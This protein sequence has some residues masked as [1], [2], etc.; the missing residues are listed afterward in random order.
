MVEKKNIEKRMLSDYL[1]ILY[2]WKKF[3]IINLIIV[4]VIS[5]IIAFLLPKE[6]KASSTIMIPPSQDMGLGGLSSLLGGKSSLASLGVKAF[7]MSGTSEDVILGIINSRSA[8]TDAINKFN[9]MKYY[10]TNN[11]DKA[12]K[13]FKGD[14]SFGPNEFGMIDFSVINKD[15][16][17]SADITNY[18][19]NLVDSLNIKFNIERAKDNRIFIE[20]RYTQNVSDL[21]K[22]D[23]SLYKFQKKYGI[24]A[25]PE[26][27]EVTVK[28]DAEIEAELYKKE[29][30]AYIIKQQYGENAPQYRGVLD[31]VNLLKKKVQELKDSPNLGSSSNVFFPFKEMPDIAIQYLKT[32]REVQ[33]QQEIMEIVMPMYEQAKVQEEN[34]IPTI[35]V[36]D[37]AI[38]PELKYGPKRAVIILGALFFVSFLI[39]PFV[40]WAESAVNREQ[41]QN[42]LQIK[43]ANFFKKVI[44]FYK[45]NL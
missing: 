37:K 33:I 25:V 6:Y 32:Y 43:E 19:V 17:M 40:F 23:N 34:S 30:A 21:K 16:K 5:S 42:P 26:Q 12:I 44:K 10:E 31:E 18:L 2:R 3:I 38:P 22:A 11:I 14:I 20:K 1:Y 28:A 8:L 35:M 7:G 36:I 13:A 24:V 4:G 29:M 41:F 9:L 45:L 15:S 39:I 27:L